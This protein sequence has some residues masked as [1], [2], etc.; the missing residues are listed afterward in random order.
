MS[1]NGDR[2]GQAEEK[3]PEGNEQNRARDLHDPF[4]Q[5]QG[6]GDRRQE[7]QK[8]V[9]K[10]GRRSKEDRRE[11]LSRR[12]HRIA[13]Q[14]L[15]AHPRR[16]EARKTEQNLG[17]ADF[18]HEPKRRRRPSILFFEMKSPA[19]ARSARPAPT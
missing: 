16:E 6:K 8:R 10:R 18:L 12:E 9:R 13:Y 19:R 15:P 2:K 11:R 5:V 7:R 3:Q 1:R 4:T 14:E 17:E